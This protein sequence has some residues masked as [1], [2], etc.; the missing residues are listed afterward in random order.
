MRLSVF[1]ASSKPQT[2]T[3]LAMALA[4]TVILAAATVILQACNG[5]SGSRFLAAR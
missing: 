3:P 1:R 5:H 4:V 2:L